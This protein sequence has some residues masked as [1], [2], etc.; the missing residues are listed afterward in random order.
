MTRRRSY[1]TATPL[2]DG[3]VLIGGGESESGFSLI[4]EATAE[5]YDPSTDTFAVVGSMQ[6]GR[7]VHTAT[8]L[9]DGRVLLAGGIFYQDVGIFLGSLNTADVYTPGSLTAP[10][11]VFPMNGVVT[12]DL[13]PRLQ[14]HNVS[15]PN[16][17]VV[18][19]RFDWSDRADF[20]AGPRTASEDGV[21]EGSGPDTAYAIREDLEAD[22]WYYWRTR[23]T[24]TQSGGKTIHSGYSAV[25]S[26]RTPTRGT[27]REIAATLTSATAFTPLTAPSRL[28][29]TASGSGVVLTWSAPPG[30]S[31]LRYVIS[32]GSAP[33]IADLPALVTPNAS[34]HY[35]IAALPPGNYHFTVWALFSDALSSPSNVAQVDVPGAAAASLA[36]GG[37][38]ARV[39]RSDATASWLAASVAETLYQIEIGDGPG[40][41]NV[42]ILTTTEPGVTYRANATG[43]YLRVRAV[44]G[45][46]VSAPS[47]EVFISGPKA[48]CNAAPPAPILLP[49]STRGQTTISWLPSGGPLARHYRVEG[50][51]PAGRLSLTSDGTGT[52]MTANLEPGEYTIR[53]IA[54]NE[55]GESAVSNSMTFRRHTPK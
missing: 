34:T 40:L 18:T 7:E 46:L 43:Y 51:G 55:C 48:I 47:N 44:R 14:V 27:A 36:P 20:G 26:F 33:Q 22:T 37:V 35:T 8:L 24:S 3:T 42:A 54:V 23:A 19:Y 17:G 29:A 38:R 53:V 32:G 10:V 6:G 15:A 1:H 9:K 50:S 5:I 31:P 25:R 39:D 21:R 28:V 16:R 11:A 30:T 45:A 13:R 49:V 4:T 12:E 41:A 52:S 2:P